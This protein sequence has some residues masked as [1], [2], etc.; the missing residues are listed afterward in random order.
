MTFTT[1]SKDNT[2]VWGAHAARVLAFGGSP[3]Q[4]FQQKETKI[5]KIFLVSQ[6]DGAS[7]T[8]TR[9]LARK[10]TVEYLRVGWRVLL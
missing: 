7:R 1:D 6:N 8:L 9:R 2:D 10:K 5:T 3:K 4:S